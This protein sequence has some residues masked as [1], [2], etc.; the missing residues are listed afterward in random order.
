M[1]Y[2]NRVTK[3]GAWFALAMVHLH[4]RGSRDRVRRAR[5][6]RRR[7]PRRAGRASASRERARRARR[8]DRALPGRSG[9]DHPA[10]LDQSAAAGA[11]GSLSRQAQ[12]RSQAPR[13]RQVGR[14]GQV[15]AELSRR[16]EDDERR[17]RLDERAGRGRRRR[18]GRRDRGGTG[19]ST[20]GPGGRKPQVRRQAGRQGREGDRLHSAGRSAGDLRAAIQS[21]DGRRLRSDA[22]LGY[23]PTPYPSYYYPY[24]PG[25]A[26]AAG[27]IWGAAIGAAWGGNRYGCCGDANINVNRNTNINRGNV[28]RG[29]RRGPAAGRRRHGVEVEQAARPGQ[30]FRR[31]DGIVGARGRCPRRR[32][33]GGGRRR[34]GTRLGAA[35]RR[36]CR[37][38][39]RGRRRRLWRLR[40]GTADPDGQF[41]RSLE[42][43]FD[44]QCK[45]GHARSSSGGGASR[46]MPS[47]GGA[48]AGGGG[49]G[50]ARGG[51]GGGRGGG[52]RR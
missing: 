38:G 26:L 50:G 30:Q 32:R 42:P 10:G 18:P 6:S 28:N 21:G 49:G 51:G 40:L 36:R 24:P 43:R 52:G 15:A 34:G 4:R 9:R 22:V 11:G 35:R 14:C 1:M 39:W 44:G 46:S 33:R 31:Q 23:Y 3:A 47:G 37:S 25:A 19:V 27:V 17:S 7:R 12:G 48:R 8:P 2:M 13:R 41:P 5:R 16:G 29:W 20:Q 45:S